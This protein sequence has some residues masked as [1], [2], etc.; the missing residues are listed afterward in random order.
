MVHSL[1]SHREQKNLQSWPK[2]P[3]PGSANRWSEYSAATVLDEQ[4][5]T[6]DKHVFL[7]RNLHFNHPDSML[8]RLQVQGK[9]EMHYAFIHILP[10]MEVLPR[11]F[12][13]DGR[14]V[15][16]KES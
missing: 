15:G 12:L 3:V 2:K 13:L 4:N 9:E 6:R 5:E 10:P 8:Q 7:D 14:S 16:E 1:H 11:P